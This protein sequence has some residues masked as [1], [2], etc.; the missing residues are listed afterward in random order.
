MRERQLEKSADRRD[1]PIRAPRDLKKR[2][3]LERSTIKWLQFFFADLFFNDFNAQQKAIVEAIEHAVK[4]GGDQSVAA[5]R[6]E[7]KTLISECVV[8]KALL[9]GKVKFPLIVAAT[10]PDAQNILGNI[11]R[12]FEVNELL[13]DFYP[14]VCDPIIALEGAAQRA[15]MQTCLG[16]HRTRLKWGMDR[17]V[18][19]DVPDFKNEKGEWVRSRC[20]GS[21]LMTRGL[22][23]AIRGIRYGS[24]R[25]DLVL[26]DDPETRESVESDTQIEKRCRTIEQDIGG[27]GGPGRRL[28]RLILCTIM[29]RRGVAYQYTDPSHKPSWRGVRYRMLI[30]EPD[31]SDL[32]D[33]YVELRRAGMASARSNNRSVDDAIR[34]A[35]QFYLDRRKDMDA[36]AQVA[37]PHRFDPHFQYSALQMCFD[38]IADLGLEA[39]QTEYQNDPPEQGGPEESGIYAGLVASKLSG[40][41]RGVIPANCRLL[42]AGID[43]GKVAIHWSVTAWS[44][45]AIGS[46]I[47]YG[48]QDVW[49]K[50]R[51]NEK[52]VEMAIVQAL[53]GLRDMFS[54]AEYT[55]VDGEI[56]PIQTA[57]VDAGAWDR[58]V[59][60]FIR[61]TGQTTYRA[62]K[63]IGETGDGRRSFFRAPDKPT[64][65]KR[66]GDHCYLALQQADGIWLVGMDSDYWKGWLHQRFITPDGQP[67]SLTIFG[68]DKREHVAFSHHICA[69][70]QVEEFIE[71]KGLKTVLEK[72][73]PQQPLAGHDLRML[74]RCQSQRNEAARRTTGGKFMSAEENNDQAAEERVSQSTGRMGEGDAMRRSKNRSTKAV[75]D[76]Q[77]NR[78][79][80]VTHLPA[81]RQIEAPPCRA[82]HSNDT[83]IYTTRQ[84][85]RY[86]KCRHCGHSFAWYRHP[87]LAT[88]P[89]EIQE[90]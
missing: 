36:G 44:N 25:P 31:R 33:E 72:G 20:R 63:G 41:D 14:E 1:I 4:F 86:C 30:K 65:E 24:L 43:I 40:L 54:A 42:T 52:A 69:E 87:P 19:P 3:A 46:V 74:C 13:A 28:G 78:V 12:N 73:E 26:I 5:P 10:G 80:P 89:N 6:G 29:N 79:T 11:K 37:N 81:A 32:W 17:I 7:G 38:T 55:T 60:E 76:R 21:V 64:P 16:G 61:G 45:N 48:V 57:L 58:A 71:G 53:F 34:E 85:A 51:D 88:T 22:D 8:C 59:Y 56:I 77:G 49:P 2:R 84:I 39:F 35:G 90:R 83:Y 66:I 62:S 27:L 50:N 82:C 15:N 70:V 75:I 9:T 23:S 67:G 68:S 47:D 18:F